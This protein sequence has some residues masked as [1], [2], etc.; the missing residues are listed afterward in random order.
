[1]DSQL[2][3]AIAS[4]VQTVAVIVTLVLLLASLRDVAKQ[5]RISSLLAADGQYRDLNGWALRDE[6]LLR[7][8]GPE[9]KETIYAAY[10]LNTFNTRRLLHE[11]KVIDNDEWKADQKTLILAFQNGVFLQKHWDNPETENQYTKNFCDFINYKIRPNVK[12]WPP[13]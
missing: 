3:T 9:S 10:I 7:S 11:A 4:V 2:I 12:N 6:Q 5:T 8:L 1:M 13:K